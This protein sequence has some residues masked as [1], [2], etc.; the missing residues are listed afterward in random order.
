MSSF[1]ARELKAYQGIYEK[2]GRSRVKYSIAKKALYY[3]REWCS[4]QVVTHVNNFVFYDADEYDECK[5]YVIAEIK[6]DGPSN[7]YLSN[8]VIGNIIL[9]ILVPMIVKWILNHFFKK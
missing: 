8:S 2:Y 3:I 4:S 1:E 5:D 7:Y 6:K 9:Q